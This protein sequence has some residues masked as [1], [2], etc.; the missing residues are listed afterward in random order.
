VFAAWPATLKTRNETTLRYP[1]ENEKQQPGT[2]Q[3]KRWEE[4][5]KHEV[6]EDYTHSSV[7]ATGASFTSL[8][9][10]L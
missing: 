10:Q 8:S 9:F 4:K 7:L 5:Q 3:R 1:N 2:G 6:N